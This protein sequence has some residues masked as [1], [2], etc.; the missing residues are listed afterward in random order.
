MEE[1]NSEQFQAWVEGQGQRI[2]QDND[3]SPFQSDLPPAAP[4]Q[5]KE[6][7]ELD[8]SQLATEAKLAT[9]SE[10]RAAT[11]KAFDQIEAE[12]REEVVQ[13]AVLPLIKRIDS[14]LGKNGL[15]A[16]T[17][18]EVADFRQLEDSTIRKNAIR[19]KPESEQLTAI[20][21][22]TRNLAWRLKQAADEQ[23]A[24]EIGVEEQ[25]QRETF[26]DQ[27]KPARRTKSILGA[28]LK[29]MLGRPSEKKRSQL[30]DESQ[31]KQ[32]PLKNQASEE[33]MD[34]ALTD[35]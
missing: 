31:L 33:E 15:R 22:K 20:N 8:T 27:K 34:Q 28:Y 30:D 12:Q 16:Q 9:A 4:E 32:W 6:R 23:E 13:N 14:R 1:V 35:L 29:A 26:A 18:Q 10:Q 17:R 11:N 5:L 25:A 3:H 24:R 19:N 2:D 7:P 21:E